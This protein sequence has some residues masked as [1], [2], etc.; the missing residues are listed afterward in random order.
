MTSQVTW[1]HYKKSSTQVSNECCI[2]LLLII[3]IILGRP[4]KGEYSRLSNAEKWKLCRSKG[5]EQKKKNHDLRKKLC[6]TKLKGN[7]LKY[8]QHKVNERY[9]KLQNKGNKAVEVEELGQCS[10]SPDSSFSNKQAIHLMLTI[11]YQK[12]RTKKQKSSKN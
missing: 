4:S 8:E 12:V 2:D 1:W 9:C 5:S 6:S 10:S 7:P 3:F 11:T